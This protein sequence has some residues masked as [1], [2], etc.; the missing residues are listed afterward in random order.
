MFE[1]DRQQSVQVSAKTMKAV[2]RQRE[3]FVQSLGGMQ[4]VKPRSDSPSLV[5][6]ICL[7]KR[8]GV[9]AHFLELLRLEEYVHN[10]TRAPSLFTYE[11]NQVVHI[12]SMS[13]TPWVNN[14]CVGQRVRFLPSVLVPAEEH[15]TTRCMR[16]R[17]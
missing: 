16:S 2:M 7:T 13:L 11:V 8:F 5:S 14:R 12:W 3:Y 6:A 1:V 15:E 10:R 4:V 9:V 17:R